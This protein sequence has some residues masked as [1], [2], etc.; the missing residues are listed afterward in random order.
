MIKKKSFR[1]NIKQRNCHFGLKLMLFRSTKISLKLFFRK[2]AIG[3]NREYCD[4]YLDSRLNQNFLL[5]YI[6]VPTYVH[7]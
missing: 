7:A 6:G 3:K 1:R 5:M 4:Q 2:N